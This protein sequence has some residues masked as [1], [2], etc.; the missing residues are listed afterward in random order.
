[1]TD[2][3]LHPDD[4]DSCWQ[5]PIKGA[6]YDEGDRWWCCA[7][8][9][10]DTPDDT[11][12]YVGVEVHRAR[13]E[14]GAWLTKIHPNPDHRILNQMFV[15]VMKPIAFD[16]DESAETQASMSRIDTAQ[17]VI[18]A[19]GG[20]TVCGAVNEDGV[21]DHVVGC[22]VMSWALYCVARK[23]LDADGEPSLSDVV[24]AAHEQIARMD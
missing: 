6:V 23:I 16:D 13:C 3:P 18:D 20:C 22:E 24:R 7:D 2:R 1:M 9:E 21:V 10:A 11:M 4:D 17:S 8:D 14:L 5:H 12:I 15:E 19:G